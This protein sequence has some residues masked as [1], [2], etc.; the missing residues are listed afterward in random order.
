MKKQKYKAFAILLSLI[1][2]VQTARAEVYE[3]AVIGDAGAMPNSVLSVRDSIQRNGV[4][5]LVMPGDNC[6]HD[7]LQNRKA[8]MEERL[9]IYDKIWSRW[10]G[11]L[12]D[13]VALGNHNLGYDAELAYFNSRDPGPVHSEYYIRDFGDTIR[14]YVLNS[15]NPSNVDEQIRWFETNIKK[16][17]RGNVFL[18]YHHP[19]YTSTISHFWFEKPIFQERLRPLLHK[20]RKK[21]KAVFLGHDHIAA[22]MRYGKVKAYIS[23]AAKGFRN[24]TKLNYIARDGR[25]VRTKFLA[26]HTPHWLR[27]TIDE[28]A[29]RTQVQFVRA[30]DDVVT[31][32]DPL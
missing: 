30:K 10:Q 27:L 18:V 29:G 22:A 32:E 20:Y 2:H 31:F 28:D 25:M 3:F 6:Y 16:E 5:S 15:D 11:F 14:F 7:S 4:V 19:T 17:T 12:F 21:F 13:V 8:P 26:L 1:I 23:G 9:A 24:S